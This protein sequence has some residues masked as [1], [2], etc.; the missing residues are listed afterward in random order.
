MASFEMRNQMPSRASLWRKRNSQ[1]TK[2]RTRATRV[3]LKRTLEDHQ[4][5]QTEAMN[6]KRTV[7]QPTKSLT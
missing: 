5:T 7:R 3:V 6:V 4:P 2:P 1:V